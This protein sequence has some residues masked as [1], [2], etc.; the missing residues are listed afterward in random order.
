MVPLMIAQGGE[1][2][3]SASLLAGLLSIVISVRSR[4]LLL[5]IT[6]TSD[7]FE[8]K[9]AFLRAF[10]GYMRYVRGGQLETRFLTRENVLH[11]RMQLPRAPQHK[12]KKVFQHALEDLHLKG[13]SATQAK[14][15]ILDEATS[16]VEELALAIRSH[17]GKEDVPSVVN[18]WK[19]IYK[20]DRMIG[21]TL[22]AQSQTATRTNS[23]VGRS[24]P[25]QPD[26]TI[27][28][29]DV[30][31][32]TGFGSKIIR[33]VSK[34]TRKFGGEISGLLDKTVG[35]PGQEQDSQQA[36]MRHS[37]PESPMREGFLPLGVSTMSEPASVGHRYSPFHSL[38]SMSRPSSAL[39]MSRQDTGTEAYG[40]AESSMLRPPDMRR[41]ASEQGPLPNYAPADDSLSSNRVLEEKRWRRHSFGCERDPPAKEQIPSVERL[42]I[43]YDLET[44]L[45]KLQDQEVMLKAVVERLREMDRLYEK[46]L[47]QVS[48]VIDG[49]GEQLST[50]DAGVQHFAA[51][52][53][54]FV[55]D[56]TDDF[57]RIRTSSV[58]NDTLAAVKL[59]SKN[60]EQ[61]GPDLERVAATLRSSLS[62]LLD[63]LGAE[64]SKK[65]GTGTTFGQLR[66][67][68]IERTLIWP[69]RTLVGKTKAGLQAL[70]KLLAYYIHWVLIGWIQIALKKYVRA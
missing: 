57:F 36:R 4:L 5:G 43:E 6:V 27:E 54:G 1:S 46:A 8:E 55:I 50:L 37:Q 52:V 69:S 67:M 48:P 34:T 30:E 24:V 11:L 35:W 16:S 15:G 25:E 12:F 17:P 19:G 44:G 56:E 22:L 70:P 33:G 3:L 65:S 64:R 42:K 20:R 68:Q 10:D 53:G 49:R 13:E 28:H 2:L 38:L 66:E 58:D 14:G 41:A 39:D 9:K 29:I 23:T 18:L 62:A 7:P 47:Q 61:N 51:E 40:L 31:D 26:P 45:Q 21:R 60:T 59:K 32:E 63:G